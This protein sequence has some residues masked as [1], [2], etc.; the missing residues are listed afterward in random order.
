[1]SEH[2]AHDLRENLESLTG[3][4]LDF[5]ERLM[6]IEFPVPLNLSGIRPVRSRS[7]ASKIIMTMESITNQRTHP[8][9][10]RLITQ[11]PNRGEQ[12]QVAR[13]SGIRD[14]SGYQPVALILNT[15]YRDMCT[16]KRSTMRKGT[17]MKSTMTRSMSTRVKMFESMRGNA[18][19]ML[20]GE[21]TM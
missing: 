9:P 7:T 21:S 13:I 1:M 5:R 20:E 4:R 15:A 18:A 10:G 12:R 14:F 11:I 2:L 3:M 19:L 16:L 8:I 6:I 17:T